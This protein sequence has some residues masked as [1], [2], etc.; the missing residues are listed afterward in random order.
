MVPPPHSLF[1][2]QKMIELFFLGVGVSGGKNDLSSLFFLCFNFYFFCEKKLI[3]PVE[4]FIKIINFL[5]LP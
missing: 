1:P 2:S 3:I 5:T 4:N